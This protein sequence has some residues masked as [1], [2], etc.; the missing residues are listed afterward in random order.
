MSQ[1]K[2]KFAIKHVGLIWSLEFKS[3]L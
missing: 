1:F 2:V 3:F